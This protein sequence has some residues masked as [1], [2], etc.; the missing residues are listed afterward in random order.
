MMKLFRYLGV[1][2]IK[3]AIKVANTPF[4]M[5]ISVSFDKYKKLTDK[6]K[7]VCKKIIEERT[8]AKCDLF[9]IYHDTKYKSSGKGY[10]GSR[11]EVL[12]SYG[13]LET[14]QLY[15]LP[16][17]DGE[18]YT[19]TVFPYNKH[20]MVILLNGSSYK[21]PHPAKW[22][23]IAEETE[24]KCIYKRTAMKGYLHKFA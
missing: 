1:D 9:H 19:L 17:K 15:D 14:I 2:N 20:S 5:S 4:L 3:E 13:E 21:V 8:G 24:V 10:T 6:Q 23:Q 12:H 16:F 7:E 18:E 11:E 22:E